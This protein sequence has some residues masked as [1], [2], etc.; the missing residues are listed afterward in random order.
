MPT[1]NP[2]HDPRQKDN[3]TIDLM[4]N[5]RQKKTSTID[6][7]NTPDLSPESQIATHVRGKNGQYRELVINKNCC[8]IEYQQAVEAVTAIPL[9]Q[10]TLKLGGKW[11]GLNAVGTLESLGFRNNSFVDVHHRILGGARSK[12]SARKAQE[13]SPPL[14]MFD[15]ARKHLF[16]SKF[17]V[18]VSSCDPY[19]NIRAVTSRGLW[20]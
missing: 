20:C 15:Q 2:M 9:V 17:Y 1:I 5:P 7:M 14:N 16:P 12:Q 19:S 8:L 13:I 3:S 4:N 11:I 10:Q 6:P 18:A